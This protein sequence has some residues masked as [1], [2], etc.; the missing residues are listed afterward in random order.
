MPD[1]RI[2]DAVVISI[3]GPALQAPCMCDGCVSKVGD[4]PEY[5]T[6]AK[7]TGFDCEYDYFSSERKIRYVWAVT[8]HKR[9]SCNHRI[10]TYCTKKEIAEQ[11]ASQNE[12]QKK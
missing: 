1:F 4:E 11:K 10:V 7:L 2:N 12:P 3:D 5:L 6:S 8:C 9:A